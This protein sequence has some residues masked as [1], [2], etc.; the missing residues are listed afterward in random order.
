MYPV[1]PVVVYPGWSVISPQATKRIWV[2][3]H[4]QLEW[5]IPKVPQSL[6]QEEVDSVTS[7]LTERNRS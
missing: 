6:T 2:L 7:A 5:E 4:K 3:N 1:I